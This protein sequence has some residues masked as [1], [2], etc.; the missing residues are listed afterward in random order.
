[1]LRPDSWAKA[2]VVR[3]W[4]PVRGLAL[5]KAHDHSA[6]ASSHLESGVIME[7]QVRGCCED[8]LSEMA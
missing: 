1:M 3:V 6:S 5:G 8:W 2:G 4:L 7:P